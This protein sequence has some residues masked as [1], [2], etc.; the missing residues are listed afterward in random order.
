MKK[1]FSNAVNNPIISGSVIIF[2]G[3]FAGNLFNFLFNFF[4]TRN[5]SISDYGTLAAFASIILLVALAVESFMPTVIHFAGSYFANKKI[6]KVSALFWKLNFFF[7]FSGLLIVFSFTLFGNL[8]GQFFNMQDTSLMPLLGIVVFFASIVTLN[9]G[10]LAARLS[11]GFLSF[12]TFFSSMLKLLIGVFLIW[13]GLGVTGALLAF[14]AAYSSQ[15]FFSF[16]PL[17]FVFKYMAK[18]K[19]IG[20]KEILA[21]GAPSAVAML[22]LTMFMTT[23]IILV[24]HFYSPQEAGVYAGMSLL[25]KIIYFFSAPISLV[26]FPLV[27]QK[28]NRNESHKNLFLISIFLVGFSSICITVFYYLFPSFSIL[29]LLKQEEYLVIQ[30]ILW[31]FGVFMILYAL[32]WVTANYFLSI[33]KTNI[34][35]PILIG[36][37]FQAITLW[38]YHPTFLTVIYISMIATSFPLISILLFNLKIH[39]TTRET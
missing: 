14:L 36:A 25:G 39:G 15:Y 24:K 22:C 34:Y 13:Q 4:M 26:L 30:S 21:Y 28:H 7:I 31:I 16:F 17:K 12:F 11:F 37:L 35:K 29:F 6:G 19:I 8:I 23:D 33:R 2:I 27:V 10:M 18:E 20:I 38:F 1:I 5:L 3:T 32:L 9:R